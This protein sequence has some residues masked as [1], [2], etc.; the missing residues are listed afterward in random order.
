M[1]WHTCFGRCLIKGGWRARCAWLK[2]LW[3]TLLSVPKSLKVFY[4]RHKRV[5]WTVLCFRKSL[6]QRFG[7]VFILFCNRNREVLGVRIRLGLKVG[8]MGWKLL[9]LSHE[10]R[11]N[12]E[13]RSKM[14][15]IRTETVE[16]FKNENLMATYMW[17]V[18]DNPGHLGL[19]LC[20]E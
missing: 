19:H 17:E 14:R 11:W 18:M 6:H 4:L 12:P 13:L 3:F 20:F 15:A 1:V 5:S 8:H 16:M 9:Q 10:R 2:S 7:S